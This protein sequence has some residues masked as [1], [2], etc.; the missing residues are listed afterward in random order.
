[1]TN[2]VKGA[3][4]QTTLSNQSNQEGRKEKSLENNEIA[5]L[6]IW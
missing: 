6:G 1:M 3:G 4:S 5:S 2:R